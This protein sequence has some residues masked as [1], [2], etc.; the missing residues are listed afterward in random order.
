MTQA[1]D[2]PARGLKPGP[3]QWCKACDSYVNPVTYT[4]RCNNS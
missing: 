3:E 1:D 4:C 2:T